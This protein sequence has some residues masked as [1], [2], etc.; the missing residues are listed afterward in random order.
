MVTLPAV[1]GAD[2]LVADDL[3]VLVEPPGRSGQRRITA[4]RL[5]GGEPAWQV[6]LPTEGRY[7]GVAQQGETLLVTGHEVGPDG[8]G[9]LTIALDRRTGAYRWQQPG[10][11]SALPDGNILIWS[12]R[13]R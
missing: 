5:P 3:F 6:P 9:T 10:N 2:A 13:Q 12:D 1:L 11:T 7:W 4:T 8:Q